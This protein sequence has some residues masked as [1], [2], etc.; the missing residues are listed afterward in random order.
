LIVV[1]APVSFAGDHA[2]VAPRFIPIAPA[3]PAAPAVEPRLEGPAETVQRIL[4]GLQSVVDPAIGAS[5]VDLHWIRSLTV[6]D[7]EA[8]LTVTFA[9]R[10]PRERQL[11]EQSFAVMRQLL[12]DTDVFVHHA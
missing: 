6:G 12:P 9:P 8:D 1:K 4:R 7:G 11:A 3:V 10:S 5:I 2:P